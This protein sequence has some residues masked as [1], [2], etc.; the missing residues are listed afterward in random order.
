MNL[1]VISCEGESEKPAVIFIHGLGMNKDIWVNPSNSRVLGEK[2]P[3]RILLDRR[4]FSDESSFYGESLLGRH[5]TGASSFQENL[6]NLQ[7]LFDDFRI[8]GN[9]VVT[10]S[11]RRPAGPI[12]AAVKELGS[13]V[14]STKKMKNNGIILVGHSRGGLIGRKYLSHGD[15]SI[16]G[17]VT[18]S[19]P[20]R[21]SSVANVAKYLFPL[22]SLMD[23]LI[24]QGDRGTLSFAVKRICEF[25]RSNALK[26]LRPESAFFR[27]LKDGPLGWVRYISAGGTNPTLLR[28]GGISIPDILEK[29]IPEKFYPEELKKGKG[30][31]LVSTESSRIPWSDEHYNFDCNHAE[32]LFEKE[33]RE[34]LG[35]AINRIVCR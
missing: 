5:A 18:I 33:A 16:K 22:V 21:G 14:R 17:L 8:K 7:T 6:R 35:E 9:T 25:L 30:D 19:T 26:E 2:F 3:L 32:I 29:V 12:A 23:P 31:G 11:Q 10:W 1:D 20:H 24:P 27:N 28:I 34:K 4:L 15:R 13:I